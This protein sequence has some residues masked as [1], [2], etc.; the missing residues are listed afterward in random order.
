MI[1]P[2]ITSKTNILSPPPRRRWKITHTQT[3]YLKLFFSSR[4][5]PSQN[6]LDQI[7]STLGVTK[8]QVKVWFQNH[9]QRRHLVSF[10]Y[11][12]IQN[13]VSVNDLNDTVTPDV[14]NGLFDTILNSEDNIY[15]NDNLT[16]DYN[17]TS[18]VVQ[19]N[20]PLPC[21]VKQKDSDLTLDHLID[22]SFIE[23]T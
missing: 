16:S 6:D 7:S 17:I 10:Y 3:S 15:N 14:I 23:S 20:I 22:L 21:I 5:F 19:D 4:P 2:N 18:H 8:R 11:Q 9:R 12:N 13:H 1:I